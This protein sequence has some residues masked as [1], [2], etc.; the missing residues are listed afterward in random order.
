MTADVPPPRPDLTGPETDELL[1]PAAELAIEMARAGLRQ[2]PPAEVPT[3]LRPVL[4]H[5]K[6]TRA[7]LATVRRV[8]EDDPGFRSRLA[9]AVGAVT[10]EAVGDD[11]VELT[12]VG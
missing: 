9:P 8:V 1:R 4:G 6:L 3:R 5:A 7:A 2:H 11:E 12:V 10:C